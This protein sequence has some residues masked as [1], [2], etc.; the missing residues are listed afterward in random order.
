[1]PFLGDFDFERFLCAHKK[2]LFF[3]LMDCFPLIK[4]H[5]I[6]IYQTMFLELP[7]KS[8][9]IQQTNLLI[10]YFIRTL[11]II[12]GCSLVVCPSI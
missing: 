11:G 1:M 10:V 7:L 8:Q 3:N 6:L 4:Y 12:L 5:G 9:P 2:R